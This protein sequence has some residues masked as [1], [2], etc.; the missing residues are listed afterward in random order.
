MSSGKVF[1][2]TGGSSGIG[3][4]IVGRLAADVTVEADVAAKHGGIGLTRCAGPDSDLGSAPNPLGRTATP[5][6]IAAFVAFLLGGEA[7]FITG[8]GRRSAAGRP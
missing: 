2:V 8:R 4:A 7:Q 3:H 6:E 5:A 1:L